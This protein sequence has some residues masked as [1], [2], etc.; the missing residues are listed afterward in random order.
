MH[1][2]GRVEIFTMKNDAECAV[3]TRQPFAPSSRRQIR[4]L[5]ARLQMIQHA[6]DVLLAVPRSLHQ[7]KLFSESVIA[8]ASRLLTRWSPTLLVITRH[9]LDYR[10][11]QELQFQYQKY[12]RR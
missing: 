1:S 8:R 4:H 10:A 12:F 9:L 6:S 5:P 3:C 2:A 7:R 11:M